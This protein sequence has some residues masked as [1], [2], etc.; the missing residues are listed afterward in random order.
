M[1]S[2]N[3]VKYSKRISLLRKIGT[4]GSNIGYEGVGQVGQ[5]LGNGWAN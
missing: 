5:W 2:Y 4:S 3:D 1:V